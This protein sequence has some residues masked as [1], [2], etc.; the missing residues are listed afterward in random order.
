MFLKIAKELDKRLPNIEE[1]STFE[2]DGLHIYLTN[3]TTTPK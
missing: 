2:F 3:K 1:S